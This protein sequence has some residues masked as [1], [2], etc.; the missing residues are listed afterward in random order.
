MHIVVVGAGIIGLA[1]AY[2][3]VKSGVRVTVV[4][5]DPHGD[6]AS[7]GNA[8]GIAV[9]E[10]VPAAA[11]GTLWRSLGWMLDPLGPI[12]IRTTYAPKLIPWLWRFAKA[13]QPQ[14]IDRISR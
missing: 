1:V 13:G 6:K 5:P 8:G 9:T 11:Q 4:D 12:A 2:H 7:S 14:E 10:V 3:L